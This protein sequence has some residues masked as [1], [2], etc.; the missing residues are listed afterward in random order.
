MPVATLADRL[1]AAT[2]QGVA[3]QN[4]LTTALAEAQTTIT[5]LQNEVTDLRAQLA[6]QPTRPELGDIGTAVTEAEA[7]FLPVQAST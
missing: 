6:S 2:A 1:R 3:T 4:N 5:K 7:A